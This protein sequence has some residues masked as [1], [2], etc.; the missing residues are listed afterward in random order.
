MSGR[1]YQLFVK[2]DCPAPYLVALHGTMADLNKAHHG[3]K[4]VDIIRWVDLPSR[5]SKGLYEA[6]IF[7]PSWELRHAF[8][9][10]AETQ[11]VHNA[12]DCHNP[13]YAD[14]RHVLKLHGDGRASIWVAP[15]DEIIQFEGEDVCNR[16]WDI[17]GY[18]AHGLVIKDILFVG[19]SVGVRNAMRHYKHAKREVRE[20]S[21]FACGGMTELQLERIA[22]ALGA[23]A[24]MY[25]ITDV[26]TM[27]KLTRSGMSWV[28]PEEPLSNE[29]VTKLIYNG[30]R[31]FPLQVT[32]RD[33]KHNEISRRNPF[34]E[35]VVT[36]ALTHEIETVRH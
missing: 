17:S 35:S 22:E 7:F 33:Y 24:T 21:Y 23:W 3:K 11:N 28:R 36:M 31:K 13:G 18:P 4:K 34:H 27:I 5:N 16:P 8:E 2:R 30:Y 29:A 1:V 20:S 9:K 32:L 14:S 25:L 6:V 26:G 15:G 19:S 12:L 10:M